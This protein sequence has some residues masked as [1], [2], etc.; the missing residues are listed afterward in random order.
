MTYATGGYGVGSLGSVPGGTPD[1]PTVTTQEVTDIA[2]DTPTFN[3][4]VVDDG[5]MACTQAGYYYMVGQTGNPTSANSGVGETGIWHDGDTFP[6]AVS[7][8]TRGLWYRIA[9]FA[10]NSEGTTIGPTIDFA[11]PSL[12]SVVTRKA[13]N[14]FDLTATFRGVI[15]MLHGLSMTKRGFYYLA[16]TEGDPTAAD[17]EISE[18]GSFPAGDF[19]LDITGLGDNDSHMVAAFAQNAVGIAIGNTVQ[20]TSGDIKEIISGTIGPMSAIIKPLKDD[21]TYYVRAFATN[22][23]GTIYGEE[24]SFKTL[25]TFIPRITISG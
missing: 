8:L 16:G 7:G 3:G 2:A 25:A 11:M 15:G 1:L 21:T 19:S 23:E 17:N 12:P 13:I 22:A 6:I 24:T 5:G 14:V 20:V 4:T 18:T 9:A 10:V